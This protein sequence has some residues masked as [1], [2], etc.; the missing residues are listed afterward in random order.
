MRKLLWLPIIAAALFSA[1]WGA[2]AWMLN[3]SLSGWFDQQRNAGWVADYTRLKTGGFPTRFDTR[4]QDLELADPW[5]GLAWSAPL[6]RFFAPSIRPGD[7]TAIWPERQILAT[8]EQKI[9]ITADT[10]RATVLFNETTDL[11][12]ARIS[13]DLARVAM[14]STQGWENRLTSGRLF[15]AQIPGPANT[16]RVEFDARDLTPAA[17]FLKRFE[18]VTLLSDQIQGARIDAIVTFDAPW[19]RFAVERARPQPTHIRLTAARATWGEL[20]LQLAGELKVSPDGVPEGQISVKARNWR[21]MVEMAREMG[22]LPPE[23]EST[24]LR[25]LDVLAG[26]SGD[27]D[28]LET[29][30][31]FRNGFVAFGPIPLGAAP[32]LHIR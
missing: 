8:P 7:I 18:R 23:M 9:T 15:L 19:D 25:T 10:M 27:K 28:T 24:L 11:N 14:T 12:L 17:A 29:R 21:Q 30:L 22:A 2:S 20:D 3:R 6:F 31:T 13:F 16:Y 4:I 1:Y 32:N 5:S 26:L